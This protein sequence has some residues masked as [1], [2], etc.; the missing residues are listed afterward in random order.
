[1]SM[2]VECD[3]VGVVSEGAWSQLELSVSNVADT[4]SQTDIRQSA[5]ELLMSIHRRV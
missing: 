4:D 3:R 2:C 5:A 1:M